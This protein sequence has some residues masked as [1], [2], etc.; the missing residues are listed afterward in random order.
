MHQ[1]VHPLAELRD[2][3]DLAADEPD[4]GRVLPVF[5]PAS[6]TE[7]GAWP[8]PYSILQARGIALA[9]ALLRPA[10][11]MRYVVDGMRRDWEAQGLDWRARALQNLRALS[12]EPLGTG[13]L[14]RDSGETWLIS[15]MYDDGFGPSRLLL[16]AELDRI[17]PHGYRVALPECGRGFA[18][19]RKLDREDA[20][21]VE[22]LIQKSYTKSYTKSERPL[23]LGIFEPG[24]L[25]SRL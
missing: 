5:I 12:P 14:F 13:A 16:T 1:P 11:S 2:A 6:F 8:G 25:Q 22:N 10:D 9:W 17:F 15:L 3:P 7:N 24:D 20:D 4:L 23:S 19:A 18:F 21:M